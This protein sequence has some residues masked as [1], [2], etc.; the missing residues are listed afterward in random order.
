MPPR[1]ELGTE[2]IIHVEHAQPHILA[3]EQA[4][5]RGAVAFHVAVEIQMIARE[6]GKHRGVEVHRSHTPEREAMR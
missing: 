4:R 5:L 3:L 6:I 2:G 1:G